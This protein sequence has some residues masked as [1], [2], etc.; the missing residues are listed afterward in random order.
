VVTSSLRWK[1]QRARSMG[2]AELA[3][4]MVERARLAALGKR[5][6]RPVATLAAPHGGFRAAFVEASVGLVPSWSPEEFGAA[7][8]RAFPGETTRVMDRGRAILEGRVELFG[9]EY[10][11]GPDPAA[12]PW[13]RS[14]DGGPEIGLAFGPT[15]DYR[16]SSRIGDARLTW[17]L[18][19][20]GFAVTLAQAGW[21]GDDPRMAR[22]AFEALEAWIKACPPYR[23]IQWV[24]ALEFALRS[25]SWGYALALIARTPASQAIEEARWERV[26]ATWAEQLRFVQ[27]H[28]ARFSSAN[29][30]RLGEAAG[31]AWGGRLLSFVPEASAWRAQSLAILEEGFLEQTSADGVT[32]EHAFAYQQFVLDFVVLVETL[33]LRAGRPV[34]EEVAGR[35]AQV[36][37]GLDLFSPSG[38]TWPVGDGDEGQALPTGEAFE[39]RVSASLECAARLTGASWHGPAQP[40]ALWLGWSPAAAQEAGDKAAIAPVTVSR[41]GY[42]VARRTVSGREAR[43][44]FDAA[45]LG[46]A[47]L[48]AHGHADALM[49]L[50]DVGG[51]RLVDPGTGGYHAHAALR[52][53][54]RATAAHNTV[55]VDG[56]SQSTPGGLFQWLR[57]ARVVEGP[58]GD[59]AQGVIAA[60]D[61]YAHNG[62][63]HRRRVVWDEPGRIVVEDALEGRGHHRAVTR[64]HL[65]DGRAQ[66]RE[67]AAAAYEARWPDGYAMTM[68]G[69]LPPGAETRA[70]EDAVWAPRFL[71]ARPCGVIEWIVEGRLPLTW[72]TTLW[73]S[74]AAKA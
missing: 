50:L 29:N 24:S 15:L 31:L 73:L 33:E 52:E 39:A 32:R 13:N 19:R 46:L 72:R 36:V 43:L 69:D 70:S 9:R 60:H 17:E 62:V 71:S 30:H 53:R 64:W 58:K 12:W 67:G 11:L 3:W 10:A 44:L 59:L 56:K 47:P 18:G 63:I 55:E 26:F 38:L 45:E 51:P 5:A 22:F 21:L 68:V 34:P 40:R 25:F 20:H 16:D 4:R 7:L 28:D 57:A 49:V 6:G 2:P 1:L 54:L 27:A 48:Y 14:P 66:R 37:E 65:G 61:G 23:G 8:E 74:E 42:V 35:I 41:A